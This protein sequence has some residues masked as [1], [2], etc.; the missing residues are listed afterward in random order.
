[1]ARLGGDADRVAGGGIGGAERRGERAV[2]RTYPRS[3]ERLAM[4]QQADPQ[5]RARGR[6]GER[7][8]LDRLP[9]DRGGA[10]RIVRGRDAGDPGL[11]AA[12]VALAP[13]SRVLAEL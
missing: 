7:D 2:P 8:E 3:G 11:G 4:E 1:G 5:G 10:R 12:R 9:E 13:R 6:I